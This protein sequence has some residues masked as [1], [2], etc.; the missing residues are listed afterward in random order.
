MNE[1]NAPEPFRTQNRQLAFALATA[2]CSFAS[3]EEGGPAINLYSVDFLRA[4]KIG[5]GKSLEAAAA[6]AVS[7]GI[8]G[9][10]TY[11]F[12]RDAILEKAIKAWDN[13]VELHAIAESEKTT[14]ELPDVPV[15]VIMQVLHTHSMNLK[16]LVTQV[17]WCRR[18]L[19]TDAQSSTK[20]VPIDGKPA[21]RNVT[22]GSGKVWTLGASKAIKDRLN[23]K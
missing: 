7:L 13:M 19:V 2:G 22:Q 5:V 11:L 8:P 23:I 3:P 16:S 20:E 15:E 9:I 1:T 17:P 6:D 4:R 18:P 12:K 21:P 14:P 10:V